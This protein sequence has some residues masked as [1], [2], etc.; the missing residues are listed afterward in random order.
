MTTE[1]QGLDEFDVL[2]N[3]VLR[4][5]ANPDMPERGPGACADAGLGAGDG[6]CAEGWSCER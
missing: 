3:D 2:V 5:V 4:T 6:C 1:M